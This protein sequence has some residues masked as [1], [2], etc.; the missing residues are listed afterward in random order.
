MICSRSSRARPLPPL[1]FFMTKPPKDRQLTRI[2]H[3]LI[4]VCRIPDF[5]KSQNAASHARFG[6]GTRPLKADSNVRRAKILRAKTSRA[7]TRRTK[8]VVAEQAFACYR[9][10]EH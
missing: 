9:S 10:R 1:L 4:G 8:T 6:C 7:K 3:L 2:R 5:A